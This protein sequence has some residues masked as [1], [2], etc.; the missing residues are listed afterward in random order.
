MNFDTLVAVRKPPLIDSLLQDMSAM[1]GDT[2]RMVTEADNIV[3]SMSFFIISRSDWCSFTGP[4]KQLQ[5]RG[6][7]MA[8]PVMTARTR[9]ICS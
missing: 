8:C 5:A 4:F 7:E 6:D 9:V 2:W 3:A 1:L